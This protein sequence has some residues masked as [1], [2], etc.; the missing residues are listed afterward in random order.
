MKYTF[1]AIIFAIIF[2]FGITFSSI[3]YNYFSA[4]MNNLNIANTTA[5]IWFSG[6]I[7]INLSILIFII[8]FYYYKKNNAVGNIGPKGF[9][10]EKGIDGISEEG[11]DY[12]V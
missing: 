3:I 5:V 7:F 1:L 4:S 6:L 8:L 10:G 12:K 11:C 9:D 2:Y